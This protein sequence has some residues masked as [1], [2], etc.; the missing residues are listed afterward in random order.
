MSIKLVASTILVSATVIGLWVAI[1]HLPKVVV[2]TEEIEIPLD[3]GIPVAA[4]IREPSPVDDAFFI[5]NNGSTTDFFEGD[6]R[7]GQASKVGVDAT[8]MNAYPN[9]IGDFVFI[10]DQNTTREQFLLGQGITLSDPSRTWLVYIDESGSVNGDFRVHACALVG[11][12]ESYN[13][14]LR[15][16][17]DGQVSE[18]WKLQT[19]SGQPTLLERKLHWHN[20]VSTHLESPILSI[21]SLPAGTTLGSGGPEG[22]G[23]GV[24]PTE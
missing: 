2:Q 1:T 5:F 3:K 23:Y 4:S 19:G 20:H 15:P 18:I 11:K 9:R 22:T 10:G 24:P 16:H 7:F 6:Q 21:P 12:T 17:I 8:V 14:G 13:G